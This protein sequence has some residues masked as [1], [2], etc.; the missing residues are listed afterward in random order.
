MTPRSL[1]GRSVHVNSSSTKPDIFWL[2][3]H[4]EHAKQDQKKKDRAWLYD[5]ATAE[6]DSDDIC[7]EIA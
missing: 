5:V 4:R 3:R 7:V 6:K 2:H 1:A